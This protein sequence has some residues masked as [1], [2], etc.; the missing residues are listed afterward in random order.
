ML[1]TLLATVA[2]PLLSLGIA[3]VF[4]LLRMGDAPLPIR[5]G[6]LV[7]APLLGLAA[8]WLLPTDRIGLIYSLGATLLVFTALGISLWVRLAVTIPMHPTL[9]YWLFTGP[10]G[11]VLG[12]LPSALMVILVGVCVFDVSLRQ[13]WFG[14]LTFTS[15]S[16]VY[17]GAVGALL[18]A[19]TLA[20]ALT[21]RKG[22]LRWDPH[23]TVHAVNMFSN[24]YEEVLVRGLLLFVVHK[25]FGASAA[26]VWTGVVFGLLH[27]PNALGLFIGLT[28]WTMGLMVIRAES[29]WAGWFA[30]QVLDFLVDS[31]L[32]KE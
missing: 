31:L 18:A 17:G 4:V 12:L 28:S 6:L 32:P 5:I 2:I 30:H 10:G 3:L 23:W 13:Q 29:L 25:Y 11:G 21:V 19:I 20:L 9:Q 7:A 24:L 8:G 22:S 1:S 27:G 14:N 26:A 15:R 16:W